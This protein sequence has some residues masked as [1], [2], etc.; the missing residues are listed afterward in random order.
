MAVCFHLC[1]SFT[2]LQKLPRHWHNVCLLN[3]LS[4][5]RRDD[6]LKA[7]NL[8]SMEYGV[9][10]STRRRRL[11]PLSWCLYVVEHCHAEGG[12]YW[13]VRFDAFWLLSLQ[14]H[15]REFKWQTLCQWH[16][17]ENCTD[18]LAQR[19]GNRILQGRYICSHS[20]VEHSYWEKR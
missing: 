20:K 6:S 5:G 1:L 7:L 2:H 10:L 8:V 11:S 3:L 18:Q 16:G 19:R 12:H 4:W 17:S 13:F 15:E 9:K 14:P